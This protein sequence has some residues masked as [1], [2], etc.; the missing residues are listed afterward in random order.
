MAATLT[1]AGVIHLTAVLPAL[2]VGAFVLARKKGTP[3]HQ[4][5]GWLWVS[6]MLLVNVSAFFLQ[7]DGYSWIHLLAL[8]SLVSICAGIV[9]IRNRKYVAHKAC[10]VGAY[11]GTVAAGVGAVAPGRFLNILL[12]GA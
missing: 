3:V 8:A 1:S 7:R 5:T 6:L 11:L 9:F 12:F 10:M 4:A 2:V